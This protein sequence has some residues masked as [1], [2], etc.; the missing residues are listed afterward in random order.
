V[1]SSDGGP[2]P[3]PPAEIGPTLGPHHEAPRAEQPDSEPAGP[4]TADLDAEA[5]VESTSTDDIDTPE[6]QREDLL[7]EFGIRFETAATEQ[8]VLAALDRRSATLV[9]F[10]WIG[11]RLTDLEPNT[12]AVGALV[13]AAFGLFMLI[14]GVF[15]AAIAVGLLGL[16]AG[17]IGMMLADRHRRGG[18]LISTSAVAAAAVVIF[19]GVIGW[20]TT[21]SPES[22]HAPAVGGVD[23]A[24]YAVTGTRCVL[25]RGQPLMEGV[26]TNLSVMTRTFVITV[27]FTSIEG[28]TA[29]ATTTA[30][31]VGAGK[32]VTFSAVTNPNGNGTPKCRVRSVTG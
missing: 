3:R 28:K 2:A 14:V 26:I 7:A 30:A 17:I 15:L 25:D 31:N 29:D 6:Q 27:T 9:R 1:T 4:A 22:P 20:F 12:F 10:P 24:T 8:E 21:D 16:A 13:L 23:G 11:Y 32:R 18:L 19:V 5:G